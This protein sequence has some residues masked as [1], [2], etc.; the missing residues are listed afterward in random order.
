MSS[1]KKTEDT[2]QYSIN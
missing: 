2:A 1:L